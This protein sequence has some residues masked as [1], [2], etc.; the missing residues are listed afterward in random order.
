MLAF[1]MTRAMLLVLAAVVSTLALPPFVLKNAAEKVRP[2]RASAFARSRHRDN[3]IPAR[4]LARR[5]CRSLS[6]APDRAAFLWDRGWSRPRWASEPGHIRR[7]RVRSTPP[8][9]RCGAPNC[10]PFPCLLGRAARSP[11]SKAPRR[12]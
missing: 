6:P 10:T 9:G 5:C 1:N 4:V 11:A 7:T 8:A 3:Y 2:C 12:C